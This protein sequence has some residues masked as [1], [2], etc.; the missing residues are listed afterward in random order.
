MA[1]RVN[2]HWRNTPCK[3]AAV[4]DILIK[5]KLEIIS[6]TDAGHIDTSRYRVWYKGDFNSANFKKAEREIE[7]LGDREA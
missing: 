3:I 1:V 4:A 7:K 6:I 2:F 5:H